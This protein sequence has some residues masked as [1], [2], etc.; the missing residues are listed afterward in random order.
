MN[1]NPLTYGHKYLIE[2]ASKQVDHLYVLSR[3]LQVHMEELLV[4]KDELPDSGQQQGGCAAR[5]F[6]HSVPKPHIALRT[7]IIFLPKEVRE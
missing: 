1:C 3:V 5:P 6:R 7:G 2:Y 4:P